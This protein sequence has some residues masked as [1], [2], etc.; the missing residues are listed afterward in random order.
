[1]APTDGADPGA[2][3]PSG[4]TGSAAE[5]PRS[6]APGAL[7][8]RGSF[9]LEGRAAPG[10]YA[11]GWLLLVVGFGSLVIGVAASGSPGPASAAFFVGGL[12]VVGTAL[13][14]GAGAQGLQRAADGALYAGPSP[15]LVFGA[16]FCLALVVSFAVGFVARLAGAG[17]GEQAGVVLTVGIDAVVTLGL[18]RLL[19]V[20]PGALT[21]AE[22]GFRRPRPGEGSLAQDVVWGMALAFPAFGC[23]YV[24]AVVLSL[25]LGVVPEST[26]P[27]TRNPD[28]I[29]LLV[30]AV[31]FIAP[32]WEEAF[33]RGFA[34][35]AWDRS[36][37]MRAAITRGALFFSGVHVLG[38]S[39][40][41]F[42][43]AARVA[44]IAFVVRLPVGCFLG[45]AMLRRRSLAAP[46]AL[47]ATYNAL[48]LLLFLAVGAA[49]GG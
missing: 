20:G 27:L 34:T 35:T 22:M 2:A 17:L 9:D 21:W 40:S 5:E 30:L 31:V 47:H 12:A 32:A 43:T 46:I 19:V 13:V 3:S 36:L 49:T 38:V 7:R 10:L 11:A 44:V 1:M 33:F 25:L 8:R 45:W 15:F 4:L 16:S 39:G 28:G 29:V 23:A 26:V 37:G 14:A 48:P 24:L 18:V 42:D 6:E 41:S